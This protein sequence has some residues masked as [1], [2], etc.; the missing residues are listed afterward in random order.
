MTAS[1]SAANLVLRGGEI[2]VDR[3]GDSWVEALAISGHT[4]TALGTNAEIDSA[5]GTDT[6]IVE[7]EGA[8]VLPGFIDAHVHPI[9]GGAV[10]LE[11]ALNDLTE[12]GEYLDAIRR[13]AAGLGPGAWVTGGGW[14]MTAFERGVPDARTL[15]AVTD[16]RPALLYNRDGHSAWA[17]TAAL[18]AAAIDARTP[19]PAG[20]RIERDGTGAPSGALHETAMD[21][22]A[23][24][25]PAPGPDHHVDALRAGLRYLNGLGITG[26]QDAKVRADDV[27][28]YL[29]VQKDG[30]LT[31][32]VVGAYWLDPHLD[33][34]QVEDIIEARAALPADGLFSL[35]SV[36]IML[37]G[38]CETFTAA[39]SR[40]Y[41]DGHGHETGNTGIKFFDTDLLLE[42]ARR[43]DAAGFQLHFH[44]IGDA[45]VA[46]AL[47]TVAAVRTANGPSHNRPH[48]AHVQ[49]VQPADVVRFRKLGVSV[50][51]QPLWAR[52]E[53]QMTE[54]TLP[55]LGDERGGWQYPF[56]DLENAGATLAIGSDWP[57]STP[58]PMRLLH[59]AVNRTPVPDRT[60]WTPAEG[61]FLPDQRISLPVALHAYT[62][63]SAWLNRH[64]H[65]AGSIAV[66]KSADFA[67]LDSNP[68]GRPR[69]EIWRSKVVQTWFA[70]R[71]VH[72]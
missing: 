19:D 24:C 30:A 1:H 54:L 52:L 22:V 41:L 36:K 50:N 65:L 31:A 17:N 53:P 2:Y 45:A 58:D 26:W 18:R 55:F 68:F 23:R 47:D 6:E 15:D 57:V 70:G 48:V 37:D 46:E 67:V 72:Q 42:C 3:D 34:D 27:D 28:A 21:L 49:V 25:V 8:T 10:L 56:G 12:R 62:R 7:L 20:G 11:C 9:S 16:G 63:G 69:S 14:S 40:P 43:L 4:I 5:V 60:T 61:A 32:R 71:R 51:A 13:Y 38:V 29:A 66:G 33:V 64:E 59:V 44:A 35:T 39:L